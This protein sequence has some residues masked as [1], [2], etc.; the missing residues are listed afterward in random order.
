MASTLE[1]PQEFTVYVANGSRYQAKICDLHETQTVETHDESLPDS[2]TAS[3]HR[4]SRQSI[5]IGIGEVIEVPAS[6]KYLSVF[7]CDAE[8]TQVLYWIISENKSRSRDMSVIITEEGGVQFGYS[9]VS[10]PNW[11]W[12]SSPNG[13][14][15]Q[16]RTSFVANASGKQISVRPAAGDGEGIRIESRETDTIQYEDIKIKCGDKTFRVQPKPRTSIIVFSDKFKVTGQLHGLNIEEE[17]WKVDGRDYK[18]RSYYEAAKMPIEWVTTGVSY[19]TTHCSDSCT[20]VVDF[21]IKWVL[22][23]FNRSVTL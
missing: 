14:N 8:N 18:P 6:F 11:M 17:K 9:D 10:A 3:N 1:R 13:T 2:T 16:P 20:S 15:H 23:R 21:G 22:S 5:I 4:W 7:R 19:C 12:I